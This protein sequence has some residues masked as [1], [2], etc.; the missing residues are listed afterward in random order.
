MSFCTK[1]ELHLY[2]IS[3]EYYVQKFVNFFV[4]MCLHLLK[5]WYLTCF[6]GSYCSK[7]RKQSF[8]NNCITAILQDPSNTDKSTESTHDELTLNKIGVFA[9]AT[10]HSGFFRKCLV[11]L[12]RR[13]TSWI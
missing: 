10:H 12:R 4:P 1:I 2:G 13:A 9:W 3:I 7:V 5:K 8:V 6:D 11:S